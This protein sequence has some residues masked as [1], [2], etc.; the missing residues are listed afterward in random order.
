MSYN[1]YQYD[2][3]VDP[4]Y[5][6]FIKPEFVLNSS[7]S[8]EALLI[9][10]LT[11]TLRCTNLI[12]SDSFDQYDN[13]FILGRDTNAV[14][15]ST[16]IR[17]CLEPE[18]SFTKV[19]EF[20]KSSTTLNNS[21]FENL[22]IEVT[23]C[24]YRRQKGHNTMA[25]LHLYRS[26]EYISYSFPLIYASHSR[27]YYGTF[28]RIKNYFDA[29]KNELLFFDAFVKKL[30]NGLGYLDTPVTFNFNSLV[31]QINKNHYNIFKLF[32]PNEKILSDSKNL[33][34]TTS[35]DQILDLCVNLRNRYFHFAMG[36]K[37]NIKGTDILESDILFGIINDELLNWIAL[38]YNEILKTFC[39]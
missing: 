30:F 7:I 19:C 14:V 3:L 31:P 27:D 4:K 39:A 9:R 24:F 34:V 28:D 12:T 33:S 1:P 36:G 11:G 18:I 16:T 25:F 26:L 2:E 29:S 21:F 13:Y 32:I 8:N 5:V 10:I 15:K 22:L 37:R 20:L 38:I 17:T 35:Y 6:R 23:S